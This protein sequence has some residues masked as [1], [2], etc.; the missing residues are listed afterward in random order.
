[1]VESKLEENSKMKNKAN[2]EQNR[3]NIPMTKRSLKDCFN[4]KEIRSGE[5]R[6]QIF[7][8][9]SRTGIDSEIESEVF[10]SYSTI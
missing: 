10:A 3:V 2:D 9:T 1:M 5:L 8:T 4:E 6:Q 7:S